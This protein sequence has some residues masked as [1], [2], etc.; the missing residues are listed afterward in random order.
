MRKFIDIALFNYLRGIV[1]KSKNPIQNSL[2]YTL[3]P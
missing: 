2:T 1:D 3:T